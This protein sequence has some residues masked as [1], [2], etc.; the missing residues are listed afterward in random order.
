MQPNGI[1]TLLTDFGATDGFV[2]TMKGVILNINPN[3]QIV[4]LSH[5]ISPQDIEAGAFIL[6]NCFHFFPTGTIHVAVVDPGVGTQR[7]ILAVA[8]SRYFFIAPDNRILKYIFQSDETF[9]V[10]EVLNKQFFLKRISRTFHGRDIFA[11]VAAHLSRGVSIHD[12]GDQIEDYDRGAGDWA[13]V[14]N[15]RISGKII[16]IDHFGNLITNISASQLHKPIRSIA[17]GSHRIDG[18]SKSYGDVAIGMP[19]AIIGSAGFLE[20]AVRNGNAQQHFAATRGDA[21]EIF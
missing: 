5:Q 7:R 6:N 1:I 2:G 12:F 14:A 4:D 13:I 10:I 21:V 11:P 9:T 3:A 17:I 18:V 20:I 8:S 19:V 15:R 16:Y